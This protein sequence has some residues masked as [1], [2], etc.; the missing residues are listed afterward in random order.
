[1]LRAAIMDAAERRLDEP[2]PRRLACLLAALGLAILVALVAAGHWLVIEANSRDVDN[3]AQIL[4]IQRLGIGSQRIAKLALAIQASQPG[5][6]RDWLVADLHEVLL[7]WDAAHARLGAP[8]LQ[9]ESIVRSPAIRGMVTE[10]KSPFWG[11]LSPAREIERA[12]RK[13]SLGQLPIASQV[14]F[15]LGAER[16][17]LDS[18]DRLVIRLQ[19]ERTERFV[20]RR[21]G[22]RVWLLIIVALLS[23]GGAIVLRLA[24]APLA[25]AQHDLQLARAELAATRRLVAQLHAEREAPTG[26]GGQQPAPLMREKTRKLACITS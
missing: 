25:A 11:V 26:I 19:A 14:G 5:A 17:Y 21:L 15:I 22:C 12:A 16:T 8:D 10:L 18:I 6:R 1:M 4:E 13:E 9:K 7:D 23:C 20:L 3:A 2:A 24:F